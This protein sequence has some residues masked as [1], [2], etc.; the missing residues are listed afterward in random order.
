[1]RYNFIPSF[2]LYYIHLHFTQHI[3]AVLS[4][5]EVLCSGLDHVAGLKLTL[6]LDRGPCWG[7]E[8][9]EA[10]VLIGS[11]DELLDKFG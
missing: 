5:R 4:K 10:S 9:V 3:G 8:V 11:Q 1:M 2:F 6:G 7:Q